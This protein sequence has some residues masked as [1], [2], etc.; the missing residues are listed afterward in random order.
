LNIDKYSGYWH[1]STT[2]ICAYRQQSV[3]K[4]MDDL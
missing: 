1:F 2:Q 4:E 3:N